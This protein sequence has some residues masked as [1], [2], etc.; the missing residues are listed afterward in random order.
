MLFHDLSMLAGVVATVLMSLSLRRARLPRL[1][2]LLVIAGT[3]LL[4]YAAAE[5]WGPAIPLIAVILVLTAIRVIDI[6][7]YPYVACGGCDG[8]GK[9]SSSLSTAIA[10]CPVCDGSRRQ[11]RRGVRVLAALGL[12]NLDNPEWS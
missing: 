11:V 5:R 3:Y 7:R 4:T 9:F 10:L 8:E 6:R 2:K 12:S 1:L